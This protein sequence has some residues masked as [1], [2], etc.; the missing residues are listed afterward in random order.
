MLSRADELGVPMI[1][2]SLDTLAA[3][4]RLEGLFGRMRIHDPVKA[5][6]IREMHSEAVDVEVLFATA[7]RKS[8]D[9]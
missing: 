2:V 8:D 6:R 5:A 3:V 7:F 1:L 4:E 9:H